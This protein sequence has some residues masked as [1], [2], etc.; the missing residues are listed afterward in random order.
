[1]GLVDSNYHLARPAA[2]EV[3]S[4]LPTLGRVLGVDWFPW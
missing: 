3:G 2:P 1:M 4:S